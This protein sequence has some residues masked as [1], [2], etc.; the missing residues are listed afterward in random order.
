[1]KIP[2]TASCCIMHVAVGQEQLPMSSYVNPM[3]RPTTWA[4]MT[5]N[6]SKPISSGY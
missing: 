4:I 3:L 6:P 5:E 2:Y 1:M